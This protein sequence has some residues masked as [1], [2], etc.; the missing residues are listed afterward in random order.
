MIISLVN[1]KGG[2]GK[3]T[4]AVNLSA[5]IASKGFKVLLIDG[6][7]QGSVLQ[8]Q[9]IANHDTFDVI[10]HPKAD[11]HK[12]IGKIA[13]GYPHTIIDTPPAMGNIIKS[14]LLVTNLAIIP[15]SPSP[16]DI[17]ASRK[18]IALLKEVWKVNKKLRGKLLVCKKIIGTRV[19]REAKDGLKP[20]RRNVFNTE[21]GQR[22]AYV[23]AMN[24]G[25]PVIQ[26]RQSSQASEEIMS[27]CDEIL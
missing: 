24:A 27:L 10:H 7:P 19:G 15:V 18:T 3:T 26:Y 23:E 20:F 5:S 6:D 8:W 2:V 1:Q 21:I 13:E 25:L 17:W 14:I 11:F 22:I 9:R 16:L 12:R 4:V